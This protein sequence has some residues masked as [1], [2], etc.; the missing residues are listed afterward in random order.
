MELLGWKERDGPI[1]AGAVAS[2]VG[3]SVK[4]VIVILKVGARV[5]DD[6]VG[7]FVVSSSVDSDEVGDAVGGTVPE[8]DVGVCVGVVVFKN[9]VGSMV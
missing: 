8:S 6:G 9:D 5:V 7:D 3:I 1:V 2:T 4:G